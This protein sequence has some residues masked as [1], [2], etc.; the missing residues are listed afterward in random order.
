ML[1][2]LTWRY[3]RNCSL[4]GCA[5]FEV[6]TVIPMSPPNTILK[7]QRQQIFAVYA[8]Y[9]RLAAVAQALSPMIAQVPRD[10]DVV[11]D[12]NIWPSG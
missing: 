3:Y 11:I 5:F 6:W 8:E 9:A 12:F 10:H 1:E 2:V 4:L 7:A